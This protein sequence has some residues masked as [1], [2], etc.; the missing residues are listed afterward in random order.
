MKNLG[1]KKRLRH[2]HARTPRRAHNDPETSN[3][4]NDL[5]VGTRRK[6]TSARKPYLKEIAGIA[7]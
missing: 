3:R 6:G 1:Y 7:Y 2:P 5:V 4:F